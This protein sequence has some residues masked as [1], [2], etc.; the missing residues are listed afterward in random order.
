MSPGKNIERL[1]ERYVNGDL[2]AADRRLVE[3]YLENGDE[4]SAEA[5]EEL[6]F[7]HALERVLNVEPFTDD[8]AGKVLGASPMMNAIQR[9]GT[10]RA[11]AVAGGCLAGMGRGRARDGCALRPLPRGGSA[12]RRAG[13]AAGVLRRV[14]RG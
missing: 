6:R 8:V 1:L 14:G 7:E 12:R 2:S 11:A 13:G 3:Q 5:R 10:G 4:K 9:M